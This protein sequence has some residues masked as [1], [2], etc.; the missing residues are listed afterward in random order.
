MITNFKT[1]LGYMLQCC[2]YSALESVLEQGKCILSGSCVLQAILGVMWAGSD[3]D[4]YTSNKKNSPPSK[5]LEKNSAKPRRTPKKHGFIFWGA[6]KNPNNMGGFSNRHGRT[7]FFRRNAKKNT[8]REL[9]NLP[10]CQGFT[11]RDGFCHSVPD[12]KTSP[13]E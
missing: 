10:Y 13:K 5:N 12:H 2:G 11:I 6:P 9:K 7:V 3:I 8:P 4:L 1:N